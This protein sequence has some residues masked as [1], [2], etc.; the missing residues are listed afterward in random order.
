MRIE[1]T[2]FESCDEIHLVANDKNN[3]VELNNE[4]IDANVGDFVA[5]AIS[6]VEHWQDVLD[7]KSNF[8]ACKYEIRYSDN[9]YERI[10][11]GNNEYPEGWISL[12]K[13]IESLQP[14]S[15]MLKLK[16]RKRVKQKIRAKRG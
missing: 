10:L 3:Y 9:N 2:I 7:N 6:I 8:D 11:V 14:S 12:M 1:I 4:C 16:E 13:L 5:S 15:E